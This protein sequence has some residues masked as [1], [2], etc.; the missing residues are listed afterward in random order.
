MIELKNRARE[1]FLALGSTI[2]NLQFFLK[3][4]TLAWSKFALIK[5]GI[6]KREELL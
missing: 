6:E 4:L 5:V 3:K 1:F 2:D